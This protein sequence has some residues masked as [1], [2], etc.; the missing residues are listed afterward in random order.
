MLSVATLG[1]H[2][3]GERAPC[4]HVTPLCV[5]PLYE[6]VASKRYPLQAGCGRVL[7]LCLVVGEHRPLL[8]GHE[9]LPLLAAL[10][11]AEP[12]HSA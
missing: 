10:A 5:P 8:D 2:L 4:P 9:R 3:T 6:L 12:L 7:P 11:V 1:R